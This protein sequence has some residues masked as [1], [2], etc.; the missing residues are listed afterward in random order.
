MRGINWKLY[1]V[2]LVFHFHW[3]W[4]Q[5][6]PNSHCTVNSKYIINDGIYNLT[7]VYNTW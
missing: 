1:N 3:K 4:Q 6:N 7:A 2:N 5:N